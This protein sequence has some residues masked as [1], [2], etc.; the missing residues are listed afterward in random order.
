MRTILSGSINNDLRLLAIKVLTE[1]ETV[2]LYRSTPAEKAELVKLVR[3]TLPHAK[4]LAVGDGANDVNMIQS[5]HIGV[6]IKG[7]EGNQ[8]SSFADY[9]IPQFKDLR[10]LLFWHGRGFGRRVRTAV[11]IYLFK[12]MLFSTAAFYLQLNNGYSGFLPMLTFV[13]MMY[14]VNMSTLACGFLAIFAHDVSFARYSRDESKMPVKMS[15][16]FLLCREK[17]KTLY[18][19]YFTVIFG[20]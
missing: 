12:A 20:V 7:K 10:R 1:A 5:A 13:L 8:A 6:G 11:M 14:D 19:D 16:L 9:A 15:K 4:V 3:H 18:R 2:I 17:A